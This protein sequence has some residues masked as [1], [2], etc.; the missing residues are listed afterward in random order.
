MNKF[1]SLFLI[2]FSICSFAQQSSVVLEKAT[3]FYPNEESINNMDIEWYYLTVP[4]DWGNTSGRKIKLAVSILKSNSKSKDS[5]PVVIIDGGPG[6]GSIEGIGWFLYHPLREKNDIILV[7]ARGT[8]FS[9]PRL[10]PDLGNDFLKILAKNQSSVKDKKEKVIATMS[11]KQQLIARGINIDAYH[12]ENIAKDLHAL[13]ENL[14]FQKW[15]VYG[16]SY[17]TYIAQVYSNDFPNDVKRLILDSPISDLR[18]YYTNNTSN[19]ISSL[20]KIFESCKKDPNCNGEYP[21]LE[22]VYYDIIERLTKMPITVNVD[23]SILKTGTFTYNVEDFKIA[24]HQALYQKRLIKVLP[25]LIYQFHNG[26]KD[27]LSALVAAFSGALALDYGLYY[28]I[29]CNETIPNNSFQEYNDDSNKYP[30]LEGGL[31]FYNSDFAVCDKWNNKANIE[32]VYSQPQINVPTLIFTGEFDPITPSRN[33]DSLA[34][35]IENS[36]LVKAVSYGHAS[37]FTKEGIEISNNFINAKNIEVNSKSFDPNA[38]VEFIQNIFISGGVSKLGN[39]INNFDL[40]FF[41]PLIIAL[42]ISLIAIFIYIISLIKNEEENKSNKLVKLLLLVCSALSIVVI[43]GFVIALNKTASDNFYILAF[44]LPDNWSFLFTLLYVFSGVLFL[45]LFIFIFN[46][47]NMNNRSIIFTV[48]FSNILIN[49]YFLYWGFYPF[50]N[51][52]F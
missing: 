2:L 41:S 18:T 5:N 16:V 34:A 20:N 39:S 35:K 7:D 30:G 25:L 3:S 46:L 40:L 19:Y 11:C 48:L 47:K 13:K 33:G 8:G 9:E 1:T 28:S 51:F 17:G 45:T 6:A 44:G 26:N 32:R 38:K 23:K 43:T 21:N 14:K 29:S 12:S 22:I 50:F 36:I 37:S 31:S 15:N 49:V 4:E 10:C 27:A 24:I 42:I 52:L